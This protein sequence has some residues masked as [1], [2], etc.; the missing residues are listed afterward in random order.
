MGRSSI[1]A[2]VSNKAVLAAASLS[3]STIASTEVPWLLN[4]HVGIIVA[5]QRRRVSECYSR[6]TTNNHIINIITHR[7]IVRF[8]ILPQN[9]KKSAI[10]F[11]LALGEM[12]EILMVE[13]ACEAQ[14]CS[15]PI[16]PK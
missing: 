14:S 13:P 12:F 6:T 11:S 4:H 1:N 3:N 9:E 8:K 7:R 16:T 10:V 15:S 2:F 5:P